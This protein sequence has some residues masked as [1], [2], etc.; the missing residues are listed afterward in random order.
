LK[1]RFFPAL[2]MI[3]GLL[4]SSACALTSLFQILP[5][6]PAVVHA[7]EFATTDP[8]ATSTA[9]PFLPLDQTATATLTS[10]PV[11]TNTP[12][13][14]QTAS[15]TPTPMRPEGQVNIMVFGNDYRPSSGYRTDVMVLVSINPKE[16]I[17]NAISFPRD[18][19]V[20]IPGHDFDR[21]NTAMPY[22]GFDLFQETM[23][24]NFN[25]SPDFYIMTNFTGFANIINS[26]GGLEVNA[27][28]NLY[29][30]CDLPQAVNGYCSAGPG[31]VY[32]NGETTLW[33]VRSRYTSNDFDRNRRQ[34]EVLLAIFRNF[35]RLDVVARVP[36][37]YNS[38]RNAVDTDL[39][40]E[41]IGKLITIVPSLNEEGHLNRYAIDDSYVTNYRTDQGA[42]VLLPNHE[43]I[44]A[45]LNRVIYNQ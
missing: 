7:Q 18:L 39:S 1:N 44:A 29:D 45:L 8:N 30:T 41:T 25:I 2:L 21:L 9:T 19:Y 3:S 31:T 6:T 34:Q 38:Y 4:F 12:E 36:D 35:T 32:M 16:K 24:I 5:E 33:Y 13:P 20:E 22:G 37:L 27:S 10:T 17:V 26:M 23:Q 15:L 14:T 28:R 42:A 11:E 43:M 40:L